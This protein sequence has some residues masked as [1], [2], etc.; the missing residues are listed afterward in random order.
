[1][2]RRNGLSRRH[3]PVYDFT[4]AGDPRTYADLATRPG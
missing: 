3:D 2:L 1:V 4:V